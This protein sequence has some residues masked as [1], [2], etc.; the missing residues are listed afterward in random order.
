MVYKSCPAPEYAIWS[1]F[2]T[3]LPFP[4]ENNGKKYD[5]SSI[6]TILRA[7]KGYFSHRAF[8]RRLFDLFGL[9]T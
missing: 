2:Q 1:C 4:E 9:L 7:I 3:A 5:F 6:C 8:L